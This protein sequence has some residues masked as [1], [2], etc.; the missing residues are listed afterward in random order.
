[1][2]ETTTL[3]FE[4]YFWHDVG[5]DGKIILD[6]GTGFGL[7]TYD[8]AKKL[9]HQKNK[10]RIISVDIDPEAFAA[11]RKLFK[12][13]SPERAVAH[14]MLKL[15]QFVRADL[16]SMPEI[17]PKSVDIIMSTRTI[18]DIN[19]TPCR[20]T[21]AIAEFHRVLK[22]EGKITLSDECPL[23]T[24]RTQEE[25]VAVARWQ[26]VKSISH[27]TGRQH[28]NEIHPADLEFTMKLT[29]FKDCRWAV[30]KGQK[31]SKQRINH[32]AKRTTE[33][34]QK[35]HDM[36]LRAAFLERINQVRTL[37]D[38]QGGVFPPRY[39]LHAKK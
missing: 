13:P 26:L 12:M 4:E 32:F 6:A 23:H 38:K 25:E 1:M 8:I 36:Q 21:K 28:A 18:A 29:G 3:S 2:C 22:P 5:L 14:T 27:L 19:S 39:I 9:R 34:T 24:A 33:L 20:L 31:M 10:G 15:V 30:F 11:A 35:I 7:T 17:A 16:S 37:F